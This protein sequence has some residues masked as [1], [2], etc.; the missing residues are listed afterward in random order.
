VNDDSSPDVPTAGSLQFTV[1]VG[2]VRD[3]GTVTAYLKFAN[4][5]E[6]T[7]LRAVVA[8][9]IAVGQTGRAPLG[10]PRTHDRPLPAGMTAWV[11]AQDVARAMSCSHS[12]AHEY[13]RA[14]AGRPIGTGHLLRVPVDIWET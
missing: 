8:S 9:Q 13:L 5:V 2:P 7:A 6:A 4:A 3:D 10:D 12:K 1:T 11:S 14:A